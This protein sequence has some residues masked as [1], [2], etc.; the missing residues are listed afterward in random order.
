MS[1]HDNDPAGGVTPAA[2]T[3]IAYCTVVESIGYS[4]DGEVVHAT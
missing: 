1:C 2:G 4:A 3:V